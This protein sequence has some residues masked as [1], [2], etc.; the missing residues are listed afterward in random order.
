VRSFLTGT[1]I[2]KAFLNIHTR[3]TG[4]NE[5]SHGT[6]GESLIRERTDYYAME[7]MAMAQLLEDNRFCT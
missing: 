7:A 6:F 1:S 3:G 4:S 5:S 2:N